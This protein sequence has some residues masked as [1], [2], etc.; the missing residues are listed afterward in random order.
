[1]VM[2]GIDL[3]LA[4]N[5]RSWEKYCI[6]YSIVYT[7]QLLYPGIVV[8]HSEAL[9]DNSLLDVGGSSAPAMNISASSKLLASRARAACNSRVS[10]VFSSF[11]FDLGVRGFLV[12][13]F[14]SPRVTCAARYSRLGLDPANTGFRGMY[15]HREAEPDRDKSGCKDAFGCSNN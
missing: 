4:E 10:G 2:I 15:L 6:L 14:F 11:F 7:L 1:M 12:A 13:A 8:I 5:G 9:F 3:E